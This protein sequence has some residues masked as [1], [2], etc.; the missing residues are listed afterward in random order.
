MRTSTGRY[1]RRFAESGQTF[2]AGKKRSQ[3]S[4]GP[5]GLSENPVGADESCDLLAL[6]NQGRL[7]LLINVP[8]PVSVKISSRIALGTRPSMI[9]ELPTP[10]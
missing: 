5:T 4:P 9:S 2:P 3:L 10:P 8:T 1:V 7:R 6:L